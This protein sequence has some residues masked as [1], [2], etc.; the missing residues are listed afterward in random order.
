MKEDT[1]TKIQEL[2][3]TCNELN[4]PDYEIT[5]VLE[6][7]IRWYKNKKPITKTEPLIDGER[8]YDEPNIFSD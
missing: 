2:L 7:L 3:N 1:K 6:D 8:S 5:D 4:I